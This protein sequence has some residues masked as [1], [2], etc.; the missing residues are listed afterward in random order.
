MKTNYYFTNSNIPIGYIGILYRLGSDFEPTGYKGTH[1]LMEHLMYK[2]FQSFWPTLTRLGISHNAYTEPDK[3]SF[4]FEGLNECL[5]KVGKDLFDVI[6]SGNCFWTPEEFEVEKCTVIQEYKDVFNS[7]YDGAVANAFR[8]LYNYFDPIGCLH[9]I[10]AFSFQDSL[11]FSKRFRTPDLV[12]QV[13]KQFISPTYHEIITNPK[14]E[15]AQPPSLQFGLY[16]VHQETV[17]VEDKSVIGLIG[18][19]PIVGD[20]ILLNR[21]RFV[22]DCLNDGLES[23]LLNKIQI[24]NGLSYFSDGRLN[25][26]Y[27]QGVI[28]FFSCTDKENASTLKKI[29]KEFFSGDLKRHISRNR[30]DDCIGSKEITL[31]LCN[32]LP[33]NGVKLTVMDNSPFD[34][35]WDFSYTDALMILNQYFKFNSFIEFEY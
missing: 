10:E 21:I 20:R 22:L 9:D 4:Y 8:R 18:R 3:L 5:D 19:E 33:H 25:F 27:D 17:P 13:G 7:Q 31:K 29:Y 12:C 23:P 14:F 30:F 34:G 24:E 15:L 32:V 26:L 28:T 1:H 16:D 35:L 2:S 11:E 6:T